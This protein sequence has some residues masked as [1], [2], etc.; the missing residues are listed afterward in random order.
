MLFKDLM[1][2]LQSRLAL[3]NSGGFFLL[4]LDM[5]SLV[6][7][8]YMDAIHSIGSHILKKKLNIECNNIASSYM[9]NRKKS[10][11]VS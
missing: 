7:D 11:N 10:W 5:P 9:K 4:L 2:G 1:G 8:D 3:G 6:E